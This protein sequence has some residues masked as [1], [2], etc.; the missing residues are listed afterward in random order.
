MPEGPEILFFS[1]FLKRKFM[2]GKVSDI[3]SNTD[4]L[5][6]IPI[7]LEG[8]VVDICSK[9]KLLW[10]KMKSTIANKYYYM[11]IHLGIS[12]WILF[13]E[14]KLFVKYEFKLKTINNKEHM[15]YIEDKIRL[16]KLQIYDEFEHSQIL[17]KLGTEIFTQEFTLEKFKSV[18]KKRNVI[19]ASFLLKQDIF[20]GIG[21]Y[22]K[23]EVLHMGNL[24]PDIK[25]G[26]LNDT[27]IEELYKNIL[28]VSYSC[29]IEQLQNTD[30]K[31]YLAPEYKI[32]IPDNIEV[33]YKYR[34]YG[35]STTDDGQKVKKIKVG[36]RDT[37]TTI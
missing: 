5:I 6:N 12:G 30:I 37:Y 28:F 26:E 31:Q 10:I 7:D 13:K 16:S 19:L 33:P 35:R 1:T 3:K 11:H 24:K 36:G 14:P 29:L 17:K 4:Q 8:E 9:G 34:I 15:I 21:N 18:I 23:N 20:C 22:I 32:N 2:M 27:Q 25:T